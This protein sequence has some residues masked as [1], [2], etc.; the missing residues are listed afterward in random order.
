MIVQYE[1]L[2]KEAGIKM[3]PQHKAM[4]LLTCVPREVMVAIVST[5]ITNKTIDY[6]LVVALAKNYIAIQSANLMQVDTIKAKQDEEDH[7]EP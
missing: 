4:E 3:T 5:N 2:E 6:N 7:Q 1:V